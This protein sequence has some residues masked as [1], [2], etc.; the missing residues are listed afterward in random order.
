M[1]SSI[2]SFPAKIRIC[3]EESI[4]SFSSILSLTS[5]I[6]SVGSTSKVICFPV[7]VFTNICMASTRI[8]TTTKIA[9]NTTQTHLTTRFVFISHLAYFT[10]F[11]YRG[12]AR[13][14]Q[15]QNKKQPKGCLIKTFKYWN[16]I[17][18]WRGLPDLNRCSRSCS[19]LPYHLAK[20]PSN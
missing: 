10:L 18:I 1:F 8:G 9:N 3:S 16:G 15:F 19:P 17:T 14:S 11:H 5:T 20:A 12:K 13:H 7:N 6:R 4:P 2:N